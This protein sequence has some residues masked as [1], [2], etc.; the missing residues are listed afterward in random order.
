MLVMV[1]GTVLMLLNLAVL[2]VLASPATSLPKGRLEGV[3]VV[4][5]NADEPASRRHTKATPLKRTEFARGLARA[6]FNLFKELVGGQTNMNPAKITDLLDFPNGPI[7]PVNS[8]IH[9][10]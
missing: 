1:T 5:A 6:N 7:E 4:C 3:K 2:A 9:K 8:L 10:V